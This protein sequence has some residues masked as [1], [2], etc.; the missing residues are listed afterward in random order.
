MKFSFFTFLFL[1]HL[2]I[3]SA[4]EFKG[5]FEQ[6]SFILGKTDPD[7][8]VFIDKR[9]IRV[10]DQGFFA[11]GLDRDRKNDVTIRI[12]KDSKLTTI[13][14]KVLK[15]EYKIQRIDGLPPKQVTPPPEVYERIKKDNKLMV[16][17]RSLDTP[18]VFF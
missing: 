11:F 18:Y 15:R 5:K 7:S 14:K 10:S 1:L 2:Q 17:A 13:Y 9:K 4:V 16:Q 3:L 12:H 6:G 8:K